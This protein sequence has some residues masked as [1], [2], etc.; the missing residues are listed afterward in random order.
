MYQGLLTAG[1]DMAIPREVAAA[2][3]RDLVPT[4]SIRPRHQSSSEVRYGCTTA[5]CDFP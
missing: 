3:T 4:E 5:N 2:E 1:L